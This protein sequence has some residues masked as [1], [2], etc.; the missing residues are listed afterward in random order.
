[1]YK[2]ILFDFDGTV[3]DTLKGIDR[4]L[5]YAFGKTGVSLPGDVSMRTFAGPPFKVIFKE[6]FGF[7]DELISKITEA[8]REDYLTFGIY[9]SS[10]FPGI[11]ELL[12]ELRQ[13]GFR[14][15]IATLKPYTMAL[16]LLKRS[17]LSDKFDAVSGQAAE[18]AETL[19]KAEIVRRAMDMLDAA[20][21]ATVLVGDTKY[22]VVGGH[23][24]GINVIGVRYGYAEVGELEEAGADLI[25]EDMDNLRALLLGQGRKMTR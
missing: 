19:T 12:D 16:E 20:E 4:S 5:R 2:N 3:F 23:E 10:P 22:D 6:K 21:E 17:G 13:H 15:A 14:T 8:F 9:E 18:G 1:M 7:D 25:V 24:A 11:A